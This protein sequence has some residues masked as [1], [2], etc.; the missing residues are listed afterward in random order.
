MKKKLF[1]INNQ[2]KK[3]ILEQH[4]SLK[5]L[6]KYK[7]G[8]NFI[9]EQQD[10]DNPTEPDTGNSTTTDS[11]TTQTNLPDWTKDYPCLNSFG[12]IQPTKTNN[13]I[14]PKVVMNRDTDRYGN[15]FY[16]DL[17]FI[18][19][20]PNNTNRQNG[21]WKCENG[22]LIIYLPSHTY[23]GGQW[24]ENKTVDLNKWVAIVQTEFEKL[25]D[26][27]KKLGDD[28][29]KKGNEYYK[30]IVKN[31]NS[32]N[33][34]ATTK[35]TV[36]KPDNSVYNKLVFDKPDKFDKRY[37]YAYLPE[38]IQENRRRLS[39]AGR[40][41][42]KNVQ[43]NKVFDITDAYPQSVKTLE[44]WYPQGQSGTSG[45]SGS[46]TSGTSDGSNKNNNNSNTQ[47]GSTGGS[48][49]TQ[50]SS[51]NPNS[52]NYYN[53]YQTDEVESTKPVDS[54]QIV[55]TTKPVNTTKPID[56]SNVKTDVNKT[57]VDTNYYDNYKSEVNK[58]PVDTN[59][60]DN[61]K[62]DEENPKKKKRLPLRGR[63]SNKTSQPVD[64]T[65]TNVVK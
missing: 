10:F 19:M 41:Y 17:K 31:N 15:Y 60:Y 49:N 22:E 59:Y 44:T 51:N 55:D 34:S 48:T 38:Q 64:S 20:A 56:S 25:V 33:S 50:G 26:A 9:T 28:I 7:I 36:I 16:D 23:K 57:P 32:N 5:E 42:A 24:D 52:V 27:G 63:R 8:I 47:G 65:Q 11:T 14:N 1:E 6:P 29:Y 40:W 61:Y 53:D 12:T 43:N 62:S 45:T 13:K 46:G 21:N 39:E 2:E 37:V 3:E 18:Q 30:K 54:T 58:T 4:N 35:A